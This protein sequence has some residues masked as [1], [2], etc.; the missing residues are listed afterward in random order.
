LKTILVALFLPGSK[1]FGG[2]GILLD[3]VT[4]FTNSV[5]SMG[6]TTNRPATKRIATLAS[7]MN[8]RTHADIKDFKTEYLN[9]FLIIIVL[10]TITFSVLNIRWAKIA[11][12]YCL[13][14]A[15]LYFNLIIP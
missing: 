10:M 5:I 9:Q 13:V 7:F 3:A 11:V 1:T 8:L 4:E 6:P 15:E 14:I 12:L 2:L